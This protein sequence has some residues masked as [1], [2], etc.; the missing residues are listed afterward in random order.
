MDNS[1]TWL[2]KRISSVEVIEALYY[3]IVKM[4]KDEKYSATIKLPLAQDNGQFRCQVFDSDRNKIEI[5]DINSKGSDVTAIVQLT[6]LW[7][8]GGKFG[9]SWKVQQLRVVPRPALTDYAFVDDEDE[10]KVSSGENIDNDANQEY[11]IDT[12][13]SDS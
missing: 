8:V 12:D 9:I 2:K 11:G 6:G 5:L 10:T 13:G 3:P 7:L 1:Q 4:P